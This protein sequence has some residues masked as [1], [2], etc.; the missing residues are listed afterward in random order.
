MKL[1]QKSKRI[2]AF[3]IFGLG[4]GIFL[5]PSISNVYAEYFQVKVIDKYQDELNEMEQK[6]KSEKLKKMFEY[7]ENLVENNAA[8]DDPFANTANEAD[9]ESADS[10]SETA[11]SADYEPVTYD[12]LAEM[13]GETLGHIEIP[14][15]NV[16]IPIYLGTSDL[17]LQNGVGLLEGSS[18]PTGGASTH[19]VLTG[20]RG[21]PSSKLFTDLVDLV[22]GDVFY[23]HTLN[24]ILAY[25]VDTLETVL[26]EETESLKIVENN[27]L[28]T[29]I[30][31]TP[32]MVN[33]HRLLVTGHR[34]PYEAKAAEDGENA[35]E[36]I[37]DTSGKIIEK[38]D[39]LWFYG[40][41]CLVVF[42]GAFLILLR[43]Q[44]NKRN[45]S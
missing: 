41:V 27:D 25:E 29:L 6:E 15:M 3:I 8:L 2:F 35:I 1:S 19:A 37:K 40:I 23:I 7:N 21:L 28:V 31:C 17:A 32:Y 30:T 45:H 13:L 38:T 9:S 24:G 20:H 5:Y 26:P 34:I 12:V 44:K 43:I 18:L 33:T 11:I 36:K 4:L 10:S 16:D 14:K 39:N 22:V 42:V